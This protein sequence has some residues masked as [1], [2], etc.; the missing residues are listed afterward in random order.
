MKRTAVVFALI[1]LLGLLPMCGGGEG[2]VST[3]TSTSPDTTALPEDTTVR[4]SLLRVNLTDKPAE[5]YLAVYVTVASVRIHSSA[6]A[7][8]EDGEWLELPVTAAMP[9]D[10]LSLRNGVL[11]ELCQ[12]QLPLGSYQQVRLE[13]MPNVGTEPP[14]YQS[15]LTADGVTHPLDVPSDTIK[16]VHSF[17]VDAALTT[18]LTLDFDASQS[19][20]E[21]GNDTWSLKPVITGSSS[22]GG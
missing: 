19:V 17:S 10:L 21:R 6:D 18:D 9:V 5:E 20:N 3:S 14:Y 1:P 2:G 12:A 11:Y 16:I 13:L 8:A 7:G 15:V 22:Q 4:S